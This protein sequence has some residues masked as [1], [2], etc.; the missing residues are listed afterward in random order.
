VISGSYL[1][2]RPYTY[3]SDRGG[4]RMTF[5]S[6]HRSLGAYMAA[7]EG[8]GLLVRSFREPPVPDAWLDDPAEQRWL[9]LPLFLFARAVKP[10]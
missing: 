2:A 6:T 7:V 9:R 5:H 8:A 1:E 3:T 10:T 4:I